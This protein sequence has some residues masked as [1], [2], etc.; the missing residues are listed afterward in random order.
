MHGGGGAGHH[1]GGHHGGGHH[2]HHHGGHHGHQHAHHPG[3]DFA[4][5]AFGHRDSDGDRQGGPGKFFLILALV[6]VTW[7]LV[8]TVALTALSH[9]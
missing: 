5:G 6:L 2:G 3:G 9:R 4:G 7:V 1:G 8:L